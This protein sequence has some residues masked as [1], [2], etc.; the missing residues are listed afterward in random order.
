M[1]NLILFLTFISF[2][3]L[4]QRSCKVDLIQ[5]DSGVVVK[6]FKRPRC[7]KAFK[8]CSKLQL[9]IPG[10]LCERSRN[11]N[12]SD[13]MTRIFEM[14]LIERMDKRAY[15]NCHVELNV[16]GWANQIYVDGDFKGN[17]HKNSE[18]AKFK[19]ALKNYIDKGICQ[20]KSIPELELLF[21]PDL[22]NQ[23]IN[24]EIKGCYVIPKVSGWAHQIYI[25]GKFAGNFNIS[26]ENELSGLKSRLAAYIDNGSCEFKSYETI[27]LMNSPELLYD[28]ANHNFKGCHVELNVSGWA[29][30]IYINGSFSGNYHKSTEVQKFRSRLADLVE[31]GRCIYDPIN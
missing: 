7:K 9:E 13:I 11:N 8:Q 5:V 15:E 26:N 24:H 1:K 28:F 27:R 22:I 20:L 21:S 17:F 16:S 18:V 30:Q 3:S 10:T 4:A 6:S 12:S 31:S 25:K 23:Y 14:D 29:N 19:R 2:N